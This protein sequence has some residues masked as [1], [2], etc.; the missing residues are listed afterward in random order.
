MDECRNEEIEIL[1]PQWRDRLDECHS[2]IR[3][4]NQMD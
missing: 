2:T 1:I 3:R 4:S